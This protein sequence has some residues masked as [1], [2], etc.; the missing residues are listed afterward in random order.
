MLKN[1]LSSLAATIVF[2]CI[3]AVA[4][5]EYAKQTSDERSIKITVAPKD[6]S[7]EAR[8]WDFEVTVE[9][10]TRDLSDDLTKSSVLIADGKQYLPTGWEGAP[11]GG[12]HRKGLLRFKA[13]VPKPGSV[14]L[15]IRLA[16]AASL[17]S[18]KWILK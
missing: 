11:P 17:R 8:T 6:I 5:A 15:Q 16:G 12:H 18:F 14:E 7:N 9:S 2:S 10:H 13:I 4:A 1:L 3:P